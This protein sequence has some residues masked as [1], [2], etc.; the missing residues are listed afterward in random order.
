MEPMASTIE[1][2]EE[3]LK[4][5]T[6][7]IYLKNQEFYQNKLG[8]LNF[9]KYFLKYPVILKKTLI[10]YIIIQQEVILYHSKN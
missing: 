5:P 2:N 10:H 7:I 6:F 9:Q 1:E 8:F 3:E 4:I